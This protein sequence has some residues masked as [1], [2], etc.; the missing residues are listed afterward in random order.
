MLPKKMLCLRLTAFYALQIE[1]A[2][3]TEFPLTER[4]AVLKG[5]SY[6]IIS[7]IKGPISQIFSNTVLKGQSY[8]EFRGEGK[9]L[10]H[11]LSFV[12]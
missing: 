1:I 4:E 11:S 8:K 12:K 2:D 10:V 5:Q 9:R 6:K 3:P 7:N